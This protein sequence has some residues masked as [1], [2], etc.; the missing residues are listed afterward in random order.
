[1]APAGPGRP[2]TH[3][4]RTPDVFCETHL[5]KAFFLFLLVPYF[6]ANAAWASAVVPRSV[7]Q[8]LAALT[9]AAS[10]ALVASSLFW[11]THLP[12]AFF[13]FLFVPYL[14]SNAACVSAVVP[15]SARQSLDAFVLAVVSSLTCSA[16]C[17]DT[18]LPK[19]FFL[20]LFVPYFCANAVRVAV[21]VPRSARQSFSAVV[22]AVDEPSSAWATPAS[23]TVSSAVVS[24]SLRMVPVVLPEGGVTGPQTRRPSEDHTNGGMNRR[25]ADG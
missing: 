4:W 21:V 10:S 15:C 14:A 5:P 3:E 2:D 11:E 13:L 16:V 1:V 6:W 8:A 19:A 25:R 24:A 22:P 23:A 18:H 12:K 7:E 20:F 9:S 17:L